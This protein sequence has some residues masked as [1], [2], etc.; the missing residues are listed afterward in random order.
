MG[1]LGDVAAVWYGLSA[2]VAFGMAV[3][4]PK[5]PALSDRKVDAIFAAMVQETQARDES[6][7]GAV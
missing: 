2:L 4:L 6:N 1:A 5:R 7:G 3:F